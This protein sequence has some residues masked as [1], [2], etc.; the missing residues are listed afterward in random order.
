MNMHDIEIEICKDGKVKATVSG[1]KGK[2]CVRS[3]ELLEEI[4][5]RISSQEFSSEYYEPDEV[6]EIRPRLVAG[7]HH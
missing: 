7:Q 6:V 4:V 1:A 5:G 3:M 2:G